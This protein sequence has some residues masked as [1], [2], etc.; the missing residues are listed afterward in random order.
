MLDA[1]NREN[2]PFEE[3]KREL[4]SLDAKLSPASGWKAVGNA[5]KWPLAELEVT[6]SLARLN[7]LKTAVLLTLTTDQ[8]YVSLC[9]QR[10]STCL[11]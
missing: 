8:M 1:L 10:H 11:T 3:V 4:Q 9:C 7:R 5:L 6:K 2:G